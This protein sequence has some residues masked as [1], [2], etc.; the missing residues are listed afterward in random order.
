M[1]VSAW[2]LSCQF[3]AWILEN[4]RRLSDVLSENNFEEQ[5][6]FDMKNEILYNVP[7]RIEDARRAE[8][9]DGAEEM[10]RCGNPKAGRGQ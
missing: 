9:R 4:V 5:R 10:R 7:T 2:N 8:M 3:N 6:K 1:N